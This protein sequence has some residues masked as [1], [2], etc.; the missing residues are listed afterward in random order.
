M[1][2]ENIQDMKNRGKG[3]KKKNGKNKKNTKKKKKT[4]CISLGIHDYRSILDYYAIPHHHMKRK[5]TLKKRAN[6]VLRYKLC[7][8]I[9]KVQN[10]KTR[11]KRRSDESATIAICNASVIK[12][13]QLR[14]KTFECAKKKIDLC[15]LRKT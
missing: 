15:K 11:K 4:R 7:N 10:Q 3:R 6:E 14:L 2:R 9:K 8:C 1:K 13:K 12:R 5:T